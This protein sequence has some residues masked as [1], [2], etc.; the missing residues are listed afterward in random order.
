MSRPI[1]ATIIEVE[2]PD[3][4]WNRNGYIVVELVTGERLRMRYGPDAK[5]ALP[6]LG[7][8]IALRYDDVMT[9]QRAQPQ[10]PAPYSDPQPQFPAKTWDNEDR[11]PK[12]VQS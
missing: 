8:K 9:L 10:P 2:L 6:K 4:V 5:G 12:L 3:E 1:D 7:Q 11:C